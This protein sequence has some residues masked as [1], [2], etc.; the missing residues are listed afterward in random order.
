MDPN[1][2]EFEQPIAELQAKIAE[3]RFVTDDSEI[4][5]SDE[6]RTLEVKV[7]KQPRRFF[8]N[9]LPGRFHNYLA[10]PT[11]HMHSIISNVFL[12]ISSIYM[13][14]AHILMIIRL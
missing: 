4:N 2:L 12:P 1:F 9:S 3:L 6:I 14:I 5:I 8:Q 11:G 13:E 10:I 7:E